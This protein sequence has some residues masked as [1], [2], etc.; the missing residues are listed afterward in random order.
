MKNNKIYIEGAGCNIGC[1]DII[2]QSLTDFILHVND[3][4]W[5]FGTDKDGNL[6]MLCI[7]GED[8]DFGVIRGYN[9]ITLK[10][11]PSD[12]DD[13]ENSRRKYEECIVECKGRCSC[14]GGK[15]PNC[16]N[17]EDYVTNGDIA[18]KVGAALED[19]VWDCPFA[20][21][22]SII[23]DP[24]CQCTGERFK[25]ENFSNKLDSCPFKAAEE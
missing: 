9:A 1:T 14:L 25:A 12:Y 2:H 7:N 6:T 20:V 11:V 5:R 16:C 13:Y 10:A 23:Y 19:D 15:A 21:T 8:A 24:F 22:G 4:S 18:S 17:S 3:K